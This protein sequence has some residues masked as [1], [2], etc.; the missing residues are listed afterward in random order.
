MGFRR[1]HRFERQKNI[2]AL[3]LFELLCKAAFTMV[4]YPLCKAAFRL[5]LRVTGYSYLTLENLPRFVRHP[6]TV[7]VLFAVLLAGSLFYLVEAVSLIVFYQGYV[8]EKK[9]GVIQILFP[10]ISRTGELLR[11]RKRG[12]ILLFSLL[13]ALV[14]LSPMLFVF[15]I[16]FKVPAYIARTVASEAYGGIFILLFVILCLLVNFFGVHSLYYC[17]LGEYDFTEGFKKSAKVVWRY[18]FRYIFSLVG[19]NLLLALFYAVLYVGVLILV[20]YLIYCTKSEQVLMA[21][22]LTA[23]DE[24]MIYMGVFITVTAQIVNYAVLA[25]MFSKYG[26][27]GEIVNSLPNRIEKIQEQIVYEDAVRQMEYTA[28]EKIQKKLSSR[29]T[30]L[31]AAAVAAV[32]LVN[33]YEVADAFRNGSLTDRETLFG[34]YITAHRGSSG[35]APENTLVALRQAI[36]DMA[37]FAEIDV[38]ET[39]D[40]VVILMHDASLRRTAGRRAR[41]GDVTYAQILDMEA[42]SWF[43]P[44]FAGTRIPTL[45]EALKLCKGKIN[46]NIEL[47]VS[48]SATVNEDLIQKV[49]ALI[50]RYDMEDQCMISCTDQGMLAKVKQQ[51]ANIKTGY[52]LSFAYGMFYQVDYID[53]FSM[54]SSFVNESTVRTLHSLGKE[55]HAWTVNSRAETERMKLL[56]VDNIITDHP[57]LVR[58]V[59]YEEHVRIGFFKLLGIIGQ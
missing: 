18:R 14:T 36:D 59:V 10:G 4:F 56:G 40:G 17:V 39:K 53:F 38:Q 24:V 48:K 52:I 13:N 54:K 44:R 51:N 3:F 25:R 43:S 47:K 23:Y 7:T 12:R 32:V 37:D 57:L 29:Y 58:E 46:L 49:L 21:A 20:C 26:M 5:L 41:V 27:K 33:A 15:A 19:Q 9:I 45:E 34:T 35:T 30:K 11:K 8:K 55:V 31:T 50:D 16:Q 22:M 28:Q 1:K 2:R 42:G 6:A